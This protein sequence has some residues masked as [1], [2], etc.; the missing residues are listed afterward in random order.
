MSPPS[1]SISG[2]YSQVRPSIYGHEAHT[3]QVMGADHWHGETL[4][5]LFRRQHT[6]KHSD[7]GCAHEAA[8][9]NGGAI[10]AVGCHASREVVRLRVHETCSRRCSEAQRR[11]VADFVVLRCITPSL[12][13]LAMGPE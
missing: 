9:D 12:L 7:G 10:T 11:H 1:L 2:L 5:V 3:A 8:D 4:S 6:N 13:A